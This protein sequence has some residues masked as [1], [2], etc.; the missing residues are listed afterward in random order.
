LT[1][2]GG[3]GFQDGSGA[4]EFVR[5]DADLAHVMVVD[6]AVHSLHSNARSPAGRL[7]TPPGP[8]RLAGADDHDGGGRGERTTR[9]SRSATAPAAGPRSSSGQ[10]S[11]IAGSR[12]EHPHA[13]H[14]RSRSPRPALIVAFITT[15]IGRP[16]VQLATIANR[17]RGRPD[18]T[19]EEP[20]ESRPVQRVQPQRCADCASCKGGLRRV[21]GTGA[22]RRQR[23]DAR[24][25]TRNRG[26]GAVPI[27][28]GDLGLHQPYER[29]GAQLHSIEQLARTSEETSSRSWR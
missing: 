11:A 23:L 17:R 20:R 4:G 5:E 10:G 1:G 14:H 13:G 9:S 12:R 28:R 24:L 16:V 3:Q 6:P 7:V 19:I 22:L 26:R 29:P 21:P 2:R 15:Q 8:L 27:A 18:L 25:R